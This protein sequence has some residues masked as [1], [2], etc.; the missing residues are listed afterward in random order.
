MKRQSGFTLVE[1]LVVVGILGVLFVSAMPVYRTWQQRA[2]GS[3]AAIMLKQLINAEIAYFLENDEFYPPGA[4]YL[5]PHSGDTTPSE[6]IDDIE[7]NLKITIPQ[8]HFI[9]YALSGD[10]VPGDQSFIV[11]ISS[12]GGFNLFKG[13]DQVIATLDKNGKAD[14]FYPSY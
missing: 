12:Y 1:L 2:Y 3:E 13:T 8:G 9:D 7:E 11:T 10:N 5:I 6:I 14:F 4:T